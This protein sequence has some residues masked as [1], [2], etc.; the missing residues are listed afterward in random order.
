MEE[1]LKL[2]IIGD[3]G[4]GKS[5]ILTRFCENKFTEAFYNTIGVDF[6]T[7]SPPRKRKLCSWRERNANYRFGIL[8]DRNV[9]APSPRITISKSRHIQGSAWDTYCIRPHLQG[10]TPKLHL[11]ARINREV[12]AH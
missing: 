6:V 3:S 2:L 5:C 8:L 12:T 11:L 9:F 10:V 4:V 1:F 7:V